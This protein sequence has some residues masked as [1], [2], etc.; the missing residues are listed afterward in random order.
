[1]V[2]RHCTTTP[3]TAT[4]ACARRA[5]RSHGHFQGCMLP[6]CNH[7][8]GI[9]RSRTCCC[10]VRASC[11]W[12]LSRK[13]VSSCE[14]RAAP[15]L[16][17]ACDCRCVYL[18]H[19]HLS[20]DIQAAF[21][22]AAT[23]VCFDECVACA[24]GSQIGFDESELFKSFIISTAAAGI[25]RTAPDV[26]CVIC[27][28]LCGRGGRIDIRCAAYSL[29]RA[30]QGAGVAAAAAVY[31]RR[32]CQVRSM[33]CVAD[34]DG[35]RYNTLFRALLGVRRVQVELQATWKLLVCIHPT[36]LLLM[37]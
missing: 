30:Q 10:W 37:C 35:H 6:R 5:G 20:S 2:T 14:I 12:R 21:N 16:I 4:V 9:R 24:D 18:S 7:S 23:R 26:H 25:H 36:P 13:R 33:A 29:R 11:F 27:D 15:R 32:A 1:M 34:I 8:H 3:A 22:R 28:R 19:C 17:E 31:R